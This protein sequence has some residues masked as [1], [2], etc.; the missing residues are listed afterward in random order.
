M[1]YKADQ[2]ETSC[3][4]LGLSRD[5][6]THFEFANQANCCWADRKGVPVELS[7]Q[8]AFCIGPEFRDCVVHYRWLA[9]Q[10]IPME[11]GSTVQLK[12]EVDTET[13]W[14]RR[15]RNGQAAT[16]RGT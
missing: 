15:L 6:S 12:Q 1:D 13:K 4:L 3:P 8:A 7:F 16:M 14:Q 9:K 5:R 10:A 2:N 11:T